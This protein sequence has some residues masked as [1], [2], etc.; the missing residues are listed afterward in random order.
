MRIH[1]SLGKGSAVLS[2]WVK[3]HIPRGFWPPPA[4]LESAHSWSVSLPSKH[5][6]SDGTYPS[7]VALVTGVLTLPLSVSQCLCV[8]FSL[9]AVGR[10]I[11][12]HLSVSQPLSQSLSL[13]LPHLMGLSHN[14]LPRWLRW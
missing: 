5:G 2:L 7:W 12:L 14:R 1:H 11:S 9:S 4:R 13:P 3:T 6:L 8:P 10:C